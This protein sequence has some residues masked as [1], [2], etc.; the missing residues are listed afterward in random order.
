MGCSVTLKQANYEVE[1]LNNE[2]NKL[3]RDKELLECIVSPKSVDTTKILV[4]GGKHTDSLSIYIEKKDLEKYKDLDKRITLIQEQIK[5]NMDWIDNELK[6]LKKYNKVEQLI[7]FYKEVDTKEYT[8]NQI[9]S[10]VN[11]SVSQCK[12]IYSRC[13][14]KRNVHE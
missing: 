4:D 8:W 3:L 2:L 13:K 10:M 11:Y 12:R 9:S 7:I 6:I 1:K 14:K 5:N